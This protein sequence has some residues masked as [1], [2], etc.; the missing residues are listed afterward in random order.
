MAKKNTNTSVEMMELI[1]ELK[2]LRAEVAELKGERKSAGRPAKAK[3][4]AQPKA[5]LVPFTKHDGTVRM[6]TPKQVAAWTAYA[7]RASKPHR[8]KDELAKMSEGFKFTK[9]MDAFI[10]ANP[11]CSKKDF[12]EK[13]GCKGM[14]KQMLADRKAELK[15]R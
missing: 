15:I 5:D 11:S 3:G 10:K 2:A 9:A 8:T 14:T 12:N 1:A 7:E 4:K 13:F 6:G